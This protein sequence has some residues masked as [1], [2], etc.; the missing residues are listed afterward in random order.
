MS[1]TSVHF[2][3]IFSKMQHKICRY[4]FFKQNIVLAHLQCIYITTIYQIIIIYHYI[5]YYNL[6]ERIST[7]KVTL[8]PSKKMQEMSWS[9]ERMKKKKGAIRMFQL[10]IF[11]NF[12]IETQK[13]RSIKENLYLFLSLINV[14]FGYINYPFHFCCDT[15]VERICK[16]IIS[17]ITRNI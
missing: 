11:A 10:L 12:I 4:L 1:K 14:G 5:I 16:N 8:S 13:G 7:F 3:M 6:L 9:F 15:E 2:N 17:K